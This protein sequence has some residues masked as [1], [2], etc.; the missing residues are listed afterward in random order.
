MFR[1]FHFIHAGFVTITS[2]ASNPRKTSPSSSPCEGG[3]RGVVISS[4]FSKTSKYKSG[5]L[6]LRKKEKEYFSV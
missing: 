2:M 5:T 4:L 1:N 6:E 3:E